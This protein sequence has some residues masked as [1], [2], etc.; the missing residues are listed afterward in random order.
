MTNRNNKS[1]KIVARV[2]ALIMT[3]PRTRAYFR[4]LLA[5]HPPVFEFIPIINHPSEGLLLIII[6]IVA[7]LFRSVLWRGPMEV[8]HILGAEIISFISDHY[9]ILF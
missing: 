6:I 7:N 4:G 9:V 3:K 1:M 5:E 2:G 8:S